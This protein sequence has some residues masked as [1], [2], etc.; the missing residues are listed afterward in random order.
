M[1]RPPAHPLFDT[2]AHFE[3]SNGFINQYLA[4][5][6]CGGIEDAALLYEHALDW[7]VE[8]R[9]NEN[10]YKS[11]RSELT[12][13]LHWCWQV[14][15]VSV[16][17]VDRRLLVRYLAYCQ[18]PPAAL[19]GYR[20]VAQFRGGGSERRPNPLWR[21]FLGKTELG[22]RLPYRLSPSALKTKLAL[23]S[24][25][26]TY[27]NDMDYSD[28]N[29]AALLLKRGRY[30]GPLSEPATE[31]QPL[32]AFTELQWS[33][34]MAKAQRLAN[35]S[36]QQHERT[37]FLMAL[38]YSCYLRVS[39]VSARPGFSPVMG[40]FRR[41]SKTGVWG[42][43]VPVSKGGKSRTVAVSD[44]LLS[45]LKRYRCYLGLAPLPSPKELT[46]LFCRHRA[47][48][49]GRDQGERN[50]NLGQRQIR[51]LVDGV[52][53]AAAEEARRDGLVEDAAE[54]AVMTAHSLRHTGISHDINLNARPLAHVRADA[55][56][57]SIDT[58][59]QYLHTSRVE[60]HQSAKAKPLDRLDHAI[61]SKEG[62]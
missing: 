60:R 52:I 51:E 34:V 15:E 29:P 36:P 57:D 43:F 54:M 35:E 47:A 20:N 11:H 46:P 56:H 16:A 4:G 33:Y 44:A 37:L 32:K 61:N 50:A 38:L 14:E 26:F 58:T 59:S 42:F 41:D 5:I 49:R 30:L 25:F 8:Q 24:A 48:G 7:L 3:T 27:L 23:L 10:N 22:R 18:Q 6:V 53:A 55:G 21:P 2:L 31:E 62:Q 28:R 17:Q 19:I 12:T 1:D 9:H 45:A 40:Q 13:F 39:E